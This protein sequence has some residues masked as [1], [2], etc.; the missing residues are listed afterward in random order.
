M[1]ARHHFEEYGSLNT[2]N[3]EDDNRVIPLPHLAKNQELLEFEFE[4]EALDEIHDIMLNGDDDL[5][6]LALI[7][8]TLLVSCTFCRA[9]YFILKRTNYIGMFIDSLVFFVSLLLWCQEFN[10]LGVASHRRKRHLCPKC[11]YLNNCIPC[12]GA[13]NEIKLKERSIIYCV[14]GC[15]LLGHFELIPTLSGVVVVTLGGIVCFRV[16]G[17]RR[18]LKVISDRRREIY[19]QNYLEQLI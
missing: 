19:N 15:I 5:V 4:R 10:A 18:H 13:K 12:V 3:A 9:L 2:G 14:F 6:M 17:M 7:A 16:E 11:L 8:S 1:F